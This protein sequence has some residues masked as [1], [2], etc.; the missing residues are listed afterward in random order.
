MIALVAGFAHAA[1][2]CGTLGSEPATLA[3]CEPIAVVVASSLATSGIREIDGDVDGE[4]F[5]LVVEVG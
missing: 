2:C 3:P 5:V 1:S 4:P